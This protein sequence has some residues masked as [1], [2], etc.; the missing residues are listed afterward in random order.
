M[1][2]L[3]VQSGKLCT[4][5]H[6][7]NLLDDKTIEGLQK[8]FTS[9][10]EHQV[11]LWKTSKLV[12]SIQSEKILDII[13]M[14]DNWEKKYAIFSENEKRLTTKIERL[15]KQCSQV[16]ALPISDISELDENSKF[17]ISIQSTFQPM[18]DEAY[19]EL[20]KWISKKP[21]NEITKDQKGK[22]RGRFFGVLLDLM[23]YGDSS[24]RQKTPDF[25]IRNTLQIEFV[26]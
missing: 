4:D 15:H 19:N 18:S 3:Y 12:S 21:E 10:V 11:R 5:F 1:D 9:K 25:F 2:S 23:G 14:Y 20:R 13:V 7:T 22:N 17:Y 16:S 8:G 6:I 24:F 26:D